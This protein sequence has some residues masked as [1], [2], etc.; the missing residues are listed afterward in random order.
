MKSQDILLLLKLASLQRTEAQ[1]ATRI[2]ASS[3]RSSIP[4]DWA[5]WEPQGDDIPDLA[6]GRTVES[7][8]G[9]TMSEQ[10]RVRTLAATTGIS[11]SQIGP[12]LKRCEAAGLAR[13]DRVTGFPRVNARAVLEFLVHGLRYVYPARPGGLARGIATGLGAPVLE[14]ELMTAGEFVPVWP[15]P[16]GRTKGLAVTPIYKTVPLAV[17]HDALLYSLLALT[18]ALRLGA[19]RERQIAQD[20]M[21]RLLRADHE[22]D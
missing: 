10:Y 2:A 16:L 11:K 9:E 14:G 17:R 7:V 12:A 19:A 21:A 1:L 22:P 13:R 15:D 5:D 18:D 20:R 6:P 4:E 8:T 3:N